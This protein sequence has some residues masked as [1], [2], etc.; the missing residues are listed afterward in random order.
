MKTL[1]V[2]VEGRVQGVFF[3]DST[4]KR[5]IELG[6]NGWVKNLDDG[7]VEAVFQGEKAGCEKALQYV[8]IGPRAAYVTQIDH[9]WVDDDTTY[10]GF[11][12]LL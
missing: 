9:E 1:H 12:I 2:W 7:G 10:S 11:E 4:R 6:L 5:A 8:A 3:R